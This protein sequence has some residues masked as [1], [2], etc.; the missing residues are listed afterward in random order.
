MSLLAG[1]A[2]DGACS[3]FVAF[4]ARPQKRVPL[5]FAATAAT[6]VV[7]AHSVDR[8]C[9]TFELS[10]RRRHG[11]WAARPMIDSTALRPKR[12]AGGG[13]LERRVRQRAWLERTDKHVRA[14]DSRSACGSVP[15][16]PRALEVA[17]HLLRARQEVTEAPHR[18][19][20]K[21]QAC[22]ERAKPRAVLEAVS[23]RPVAA[24]GDG[25]TDCHPSVPNV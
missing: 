25:G 2:V 4:G 19:A 6:R 13:P 17:W 20:A 3:S 21:S 5:V 16:A 9:L 23:A 7:A 24:S 10:G 12:H 15:P 14:N 8:V 1:R 18:E 11:A 22:P